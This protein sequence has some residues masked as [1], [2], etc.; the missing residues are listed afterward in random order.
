METVDRKTLLYKTGVEYGDYTINHVLGC[1]HGCTYPCYALLMAKRFGRVKTYGEW[2]KPKIVKRAMEILDKEIPRLRD[3]IESVHLCF[4]TDPFMTGYE[5]VSELSL[6]IIDK[7]NG[8]NIKVTTLTKGLYPSA[9]WSNGFSKSNEY[10][11]TLVSLNENHRKKYEPYAT[12]YEDRIDTLKRIHDAGLKTWVSIEPYPTPNIIQQ[13][14]LRLLES[15]SFV[16]RIIFGKL[17]YSKDAGLYNNKKSFY[18]GCSNDVV[19]FCQEKGISLH[20][21]DGTLVPDKQAAV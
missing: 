17:N 12:A 8:S 9:I 15:I 6:S 2:C 16:D 20:I 11:I 21:K 10:G 5:E 14:L 3:D 7:L 13:D 19:R 18:N 1:S 4:T